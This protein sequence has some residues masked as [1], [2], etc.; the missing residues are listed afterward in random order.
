MTK[1]FSFLKLFF[2]LILWVS[3]SFLLLFIVIAILIQI[4]SIQNKVVNYATSFV[5][6][7]TH[8]RV[9]IKNISISFPKSVVIEGLFLED[10]KKD[11]LLF[12]GEAKV[13]LAFRDLFNN[14]IHV[15]SCAL[16]KVNLKLSRIE[17]DSLFNYNF[18]LTA[19]TDTTKLPNTEPVKKS[20]WTFSID[21][22]T[23][24][25]I[26]LHY[27]DDNG[28]IK[29]AADLKHLK[30]KMNQIDMVHALYSIDELI[31]ENLTASVLITKSGKTNQKK[32][33]SVLP[34]IAATKILINNI[35]FIYGDSVGKQSIVADIIQLKLKDASIDL[36]KQNVTVDNLALSKS[37]INFNRNDEVMV[38]STVIVKNNTT[39]KSDW[40]VSL[41]GIDLEDNSLAYLVVNKPVIKNTFD[42][43]HL[44][45]KNLSLQ[46]TNFYYSTD[47]TEVSIK[48]FSTVD[49]NNF[50]ITKFETD[51]VMDQHSISASKLKIKTTNSTID[52]DLGIKYPSLNALKDSIQLM[53]VNA[54]IKNVS[55]KN[56]DIL[57]FNSQLSQQPFFKNV[58]NVT[59]VSGL[60]NGPVNNLNGKNVIVH[61]GTK[62][63]LKTDFIIAGLPSVQTAYFNF[64]NL[65]INSGKKDIEMIV[66]TSIPKSIEL[67]ENL[68][69]EI[70]FKGKLKSFESTLGISCSYGA[71]HIFANID[72]N[73]NF[74]SK[75]VITNFD[76]GSL[77]KNKVMF[78]PISVNAEM[79]GS[80]LKKETIKAKINAEVSQIYLNKYTYHKLN[81]DGSIAGEE[82][83]GKVNLNDENAAFDFAGLVNFNPHQE[84]YKFHLNLKGAD[85]QKLGFT[86]DSIRIGLIAE[87]DVKG[88]TINEINGKAVITKVNIV[89]SGK[90]Y[91]LDSLLVASINEPNKS[92][93]NV[94]SAIV[95]IKYTGAI[96]PTSLPQELSNF[97][98]KYFPF[99]DSIQQTQKIESQNF[100][101]EIQLHNHPIL[102][103]VFFPQLKEFVP[104]LIH[105]SF[106]SQKN[107]LKLNAAMKK[108][109][110]GTT[111][112]NDLLIDVNSDVN[113]LNY[114][115]SCSNILNSQ[116]K[117]D[118]LLV[119]GKLSN[120]TIFANI[121]SIDSTKNKKLVIRS[122]IN[123]DKN[124]YK[125]TLDPKDFYLM[126]DR[127]TIA[128]DNYI[129]FGKQGFLIHH[130]F[131]NKN[132]SQI[133]VASLHDQFNDDLNIGIKNFKL[134]DISRII[135]KDSSLVKGI[136][137]GN[138]LLKKVNTTYGLIADAKINNL[139]VRNVPIG[140]LS[141][142]AENPTTKKF[143]V[144]IN[145]SGASNDL[146][147]NGYFI[148]ND[149]SSS[150]NLKTTI[151]SL[152]M[153][154]VEAFS[155][156]NITEASGNLSGNLLLEG[157]INSPDVTGEITFN[158][159]FIKPAALNNQLQLKHET[160]KIK[161]DGIY[162][163]SF[164][165]LD[166]DLHT[167]IIDGT[168]KMTHFNDFIFGLNVNTKNFLLFNT[169]SKDNK[170]FY[171]KMII[172][173]KI[174]VSGPMTLPVVNAKLKMK[175]GSNFTFAVPE[176]TLKADK[177]KDIVE[178][179][180]SVKLNSILKEDLKNVKQKSALTGFDISSIIE[181][182]KEA[183]L[184]LLIDPSSSDS[185]VVKGEAALSFAIDRSGK[186]SLTGAYNVNDGLYL[187]SLE[188]V[189]K[190]KFI[191]D[192]G[193]TIVWNGDPMDAEI[194]INATYS[195]R[196][197]PYDLIADQMSGLS[198][199]DKNEYKQRYPFLVKLKLRGEL[200]HPEISFEIQLP[201]ED[202]GILGGA[203]NAKLN[204]LNDDPS[205][206]N[207]Q[208]FA[209][210]VLGRF[211]Q[212]NPLQTE[213]S[214]ALTAARTT[215]GKFLSA[216]LN[217]LSSKVVPGVE[218]NFDVQSYDDYQSGQAQ[219]RTQV[220]IGV[221]KQ[222]LNERLTVQVG[223]LVDV[224]G[225]KAKQNTASDITSDVTLEYKMTDDGRYRLKGF[226]HNQY[227]GAIEGSLVETGA[228]VLYVR[229]FNKWNEFFNK[230][231]NKSDLS[232][233][234]NSN[235]TINP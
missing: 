139:F 132:E 173:S 103:E 7:K 179:F 235:E 57:Y 215:V 200:L 29:M 129:E 124:T 50:S 207:K 172:D 121:S 114:K 111:E 210:L 197:S 41:K 211:I 166:P 97:I 96:L 90:N 163:N 208:V 30:L 198:E 188:S 49:Q 184:R 53:I 102:S 222:L 167:A 68:S 72:K 196:A 25:N 69:A 186:M 138:V 171:G 216:Q 213:S 224:E 140:N 79:N 66:G 231:S 11:T 15:N 144:D 158:N 176:E 101:F 219:G 131:I 187:V 83:E 168:V 70:A 5:S 26:V 10:I 113:A 67:P 32:S 232:K 88:G 112:I 46:A 169:T 223:G 33:E 212:E 24:N 91:T 225:E 20:T 8:T 214:G 82:F 192:P 4:P 135:E 16:D 74:R 150:I 23:L 136:V 183:T 94:S 48:K 92:E 95:G 174:D 203:V 51:F 217:Q 12:V 105:G 199:T 218:L 17:T 190:R 47:K 162:F 13:S 202:K 109:V 209:L 154:T 178:F 220:D 75:A 39:E 9:D 34:K 37:K 21:N 234:N 120:K 76:L 116:I 123:K 59:T 189:I 159:V 61:T 182:D 14:K 64:P 56:S 77:L 22:V 122:V 93:L 40:K 110:Y 134:D 2:K 228:G 43:G 193:S 128:S 233:K 142:K 45:Y 78:G 1:T 38:D 194:T 170:E 81:I 149:S 125:L 177:G 3:I 195:V 180:D 98:N 108:I 153:K 201:P 19:F 155:M 31:I 62:T 60:I 28:G 181:I 126:Y 156:G 204:L 42:A 145:L 104:G 221:K 107:E 80:G 35:N 146:T 143:N 185:L 65:K 44:D 227:E 161:K 205:L 133:N 85:L 54:D 118:N 84:Q 115:I 71:A 147:A 117:L 86:K 89:V 87:S 175:K 127:W 141:V 229:D 230:P 152:S 6:G 52:A 18:L 206:L 151:Q 63:T 55:V 106:D 137:N 130:L 157:K 226:R 36:Q 58:L 99:S 119:D 27:D 148:S 160:V 191:I 165:I 73:E 164:T 100:N